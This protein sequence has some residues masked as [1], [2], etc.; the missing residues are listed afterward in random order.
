MKMVRLEMA[1]VGIP[2]PAR[3]TCPSFEGYVWF[4]ERLGLSLVIFLYNNYNGI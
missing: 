2:I 1:V 4:D 3:A